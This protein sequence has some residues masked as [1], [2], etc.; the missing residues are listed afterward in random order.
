MPFLAEIKKNISTTQSTKKITQAMQ[1]VAATK[2]KFFQREGLNSRLY[3]WS[4]LEGHKICHQS[5]Q[6]LPYAQKREQGKVLFIFITSDKGLCGSLNVRMNNA[7][8]KSKRWLNIPE[9]ERMLFTIGKKGYDTALRKGIKVEKNFPE[10]NEYLDPLHALTIINVII[11]Y[12]KKELVKEIILV[13][14][15]YVNPFTS[16]PSFKTYLPFSL[17]MI[18]EHL[19]WRE[20]HIS[21]EGVT[22]TPDDMSKDQLIFFEPSLERVS[23]VLA[24]QLVQALFLQAFYEFKASEYSSRMVAMK[25]A[26]ESADEMIHLLTLQYHKTRQSIITQQL[27]ELA[28]GS[29]AVTEEIDFAMMEI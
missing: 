5:I 10:I 6:N 21:D 23:E 11:E 8:F 1:L 19:R 7:L 20:H 16:I 26:T 29:E 9:E 28:S 4:L 12:W 13:S 25:K 2:M 27:C 14:T 22:L 3:A 18:K 24:T 17:E 15:H